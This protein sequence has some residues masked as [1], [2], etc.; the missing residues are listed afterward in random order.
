MLIPMLGAAIAPG[1]LI[2]WFIYKRDLNPEPRTALAATFGFS[3]MITLPAVLFELGES[4]LV[5]PDRKST[6]LNSS[7]T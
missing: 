5:A 6:R 3:V 1:L 7:H 4:A 2:L